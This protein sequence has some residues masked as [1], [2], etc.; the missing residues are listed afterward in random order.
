[1]AELWAVRYGLIL[2]V[3]SM[4]VLKWITTRGNMASDISV[5]VSDCRNLMWTV[6]P[7]HVYL[8]FNRCAE[9]LVKMG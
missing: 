6:L 9:G 3:N 5:L 4:L 7:N 2:E 1:M 8:E